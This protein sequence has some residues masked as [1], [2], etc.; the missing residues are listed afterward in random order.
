MD[1]VDSPRPRKGLGSSAMFQESAIDVIDWDT[2]A[3]YV[4]NRAGSTVL[5]VLASLVLLLL[6]TLGTLWIPVL[7]SPAARCGTCLGVLL[8]LQGSEAVPTQASAFLPIFLLH[9]LQ[10]PCRSDALIVA[11]VLCELAA[12]FLVLSSERTTAVDL[13]VLRVLQVTGTRMRTLAVLCATVGVFCSCLMDT[14]ASVLVVGALITAVV[15]AIQDDVVQ[16]YHQR[17]LFDKATRLLP[18]IRRRQLENM[19]WP[20]R[21]S[22]GDDDLPPEMMGAVSLCESPLL[23]V[24]MTEGA[25]FGESTE[26]ALWDFAMYNTEF[27]NK[28]PRVPKHSPPT[29][30]AYPTRS[31][32]WDP[33]RAQRTP[34]CTSFLEDGAVVLPGKDSP[35]PKRGYGNADESS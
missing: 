21:L 11:V 28:A 18:A 20:Q 27:N 31:S 12:A 5:G 24:D 7:G 2:I 13:F 17:A 29:Q 26:E 4:L 23:S 34:K 22:H 16:G 10:L 25:S 35:L 3:R 9:L 33:E 19:L 1:A 6:T 30:P 15:R 32:L 8:V 14:N